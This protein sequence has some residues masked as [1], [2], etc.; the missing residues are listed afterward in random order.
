MSVYHLNFNFSAA[1]VL[2]DYKSG[3][4]L[5]D[6]QAALAIPILRSY[7]EVIIQVNDEGALLEGSLVFL[8]VLKPYVK[9]KWDVSPRLY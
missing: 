2:I 3:Q 7:G 1:K 4:V 8:A 6:I 5:V 9:I